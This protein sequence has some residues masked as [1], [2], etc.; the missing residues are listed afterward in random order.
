MNIPVKN[1]TVIGRIFLLASACLF[2]GM[3]YFLS[4]T[5]SFLDSSIATTGTIVDYT[6]KNESGADGKEQVNSYPVIEFTDNRGRTLRFSSDTAMNY[7]VWVFIKARES[8]FKNPVYTVPQV[9][10]RYN[11]MNPDEVRAARSFF[12]TWGTTIAYGILA[13]IFSLIGTA[14]SQTS[15]SVIRRNE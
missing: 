14:F 8:G 11:K 9:K 6:Q 3:V 12:D 4:N 10:I 15:D 7:E 1:L 13:L 2:A 5:L